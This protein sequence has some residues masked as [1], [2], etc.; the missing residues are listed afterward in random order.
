MTFT[1]GD[2]VIRKENYFATDS[3]YS[4]PTQQCFIRGGAGDERSEL[5][6]DNHSVVFEGDVRS[7][8]L[9]SGKERT[10]TFNNGFTM[11]IDRSESLN[12]EKA[13]QVQASKRERF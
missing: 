11:T 3:S 13:S 6:F 10:L 2:L 4:D 5:I 7:G 12:A 1:G 9:I 8:F